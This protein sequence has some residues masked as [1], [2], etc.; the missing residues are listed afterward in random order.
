MRK[1]VAT[2]FPQCQI[3]FSHITVD[4]CNARTRTPPLPVVPALLSQA[5]SALQETDCES[6]W[7]SGFAGEEPGHLVQADRFQAV[8]DRVAL[9]AGSD[10][11]GAFR[12]EILP[13][14]VESPARA[15]GQAV[16]DF[17]CP[18]APV[19]RKFQEQIDLGAGR[20]AIEARHGSRWGHG[21]QIL[22][23]KAFPARA[24]DR[25]PGEFVVVVKAEQSMD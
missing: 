21:E 19:A 14:V 20:C 23:R 25:V 15:D 24:D 22:D 10:H 16:L 7:P 13:G 6:S 2:R 5:P 3:L 18:N 17:D 4:G 1:I 8:G 12:P 11:E 9:L